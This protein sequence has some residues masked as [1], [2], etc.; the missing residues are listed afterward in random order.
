MN[1]TY[2]DIGEYGWLNSL[3]VHDAVVIGFSYHEGGSFCL[4]MLRLDGSRCCVSFL[5]VAQLGFRG[6]QN[7]CIVAHILAWNTQCVPAREAEH[8]DGAW[9]IVFGNEVHVVDLPRLIASTINRRDS[10][11]LVRLESSYGGDL[12]VLCDGI[13][14]N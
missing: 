2:D 3:R 5:R 4:D 6:F 1:I 10:S 11:F 13:E 9:A 8:E 12:A 7:G 14:V